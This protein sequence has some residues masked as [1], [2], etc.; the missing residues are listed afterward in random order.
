MASHGAETSVTRQSSLRWYWN[1]LQAMSS[2]ELIYRCSQMARAQ[3]E[4]LPRSR[5]RLGAVEGHTILQSG[6]LR[7]VAGNIAS[8]EF[9]HRFP[10]AVVHVRNKA[11]GQLDGKLSRLGDA[12]PWSRTPDWH[13]DPA[14][15][16]RW[17]RNR[18]YYDIDIRGGGAK[19]IWEPARHQHLI[20]YAEACVLTGDLRYRQALYD[21]LNSWFV[22]NKPL[23]GVH[24]TSGIELS[25]RLVSWAWILALC[26]PAEADER[27][28]REWIEH[29]IASG[30]HLSRH[31]SR[32]SSANNHLIAEAVG[33]V[34]A[35]ALLPS[36]DHA[37]HWRHTGWT[38]LAEEAD[39]QILA[40]GSSAE[41]CTHYL[42]FI[43]DLLLSA[44][45]IDA[46]HSH[47]QQLY[48]AI[49][50]SSE[51]LLDCADRK[52]EV[53]MIGD[54][55]GGA[56]FLV[57]GE[58]LQLRDRL[59]LV[60]ARTGRAALAPAPQLTAAAWCLLE[61]SA[62]N[63]FDGLSHDANL[64]KSAEHPEGGYWTLRGNEASQPLVVFDC[65]PLGYLSLAAHG[66]ADCLSF[67]LNID[68]QWL[69]VDPGTFTYHEQPEWRRHFRGTAAHNT[70]VIEGADQS[71]QTGATMWGSRAVP[72]RIAFE[73]TEA[74]SWAEGEHDGYRRRFDAMHRRGIALWRSRFL[75]VAD[76]V[77][78]PQPQSVTLTFQ[79]SPRTTVSV[80]DRI[81]NVSSGAASLQ[82]VALFETTPALHCG[83]VSPPAGWV[84]SSFGIKEPA[85]VLL[86]EAKS[87]LDGPLITF[88]WLDDAPPPTLSLTRHEDAWLLRVITPTTEDRFRLRSV[89]DS[90]SSL[91]QH[92]STARVH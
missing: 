35:A 54:D 13:L 92:E 5:Y 26:P 71:E 58:P 10:D 38:I 48:R 72:R 51:F 84:S 21:E 77:I 19:A 44:A 20:T 91:I 90:I 17:P 56:A 70:L 41:Q 50:R 78:S 88:F 52:L 31:L 40:D 63:M 1:R 64:R 43:A 8:A 49:E 69:L 42:A 36:V 12:I 59:G 32:H 65:G 4:R 15:G 66:H 7:S 27:L 3:M 57:H 74:G 55:D 73:T 30:T 80:V 89:P 60:A 22:Q 28:C 61:P 34:T 23:Y 46:E 85:P 18:F 81:V 62:R 6:S 11:D 53:P 82:V 87:I 2:A 39:K 75:F 68:G 86:L 29:I 24:W 14:S 76:W 83:E 79:F 67:S 25:L 33:L 16:R 45:L 37:A 47:A 9:Q